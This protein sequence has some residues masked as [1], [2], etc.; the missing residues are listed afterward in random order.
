MSPC[1]AGGDPQ[2]ESDGGRRAVSLAVCHHNS[3]LRASR[4]GQRDH[5][6]GA[7]A[8]VS[9]WVGRATFHGEPAAHQAH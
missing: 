4:T 2:M 9:A 8:W 5:T 3:L 6:V 7:T 1:Q